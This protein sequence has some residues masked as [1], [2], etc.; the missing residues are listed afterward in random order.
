MATS[1]T[2]PPIAVLPGHILHAG[3]ALS[4]LEHHGSQL[5]TH[6]WLSPIWMVL[7]HRGVVLKSLLTSCQPKGARPHCREHVDQLSNWHKLACM[8][9]MFIPI[10][11][12]CMENHVSKHRS[13][14]V[15][16]S[17]SKNLQVTPL[18]AVSIL[19]GWPLHW[20]SYSPRPLP[21]DGSTAWPRCR[22]PLLHEQL[23][24]KSRC[25][26]TDPEKLKPMCC[27]SLA[28]SW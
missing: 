5:F 10:F 17:I 23:E 26:R 3:T 7:H 8:F 28:N 11:S 6:R 22:R 9:I 2:S 19:H 4:I 18:A 21:R 1:S 13:V 25:V 24:W 16:R 27:Q 14:F 15:T 12:S 20:P